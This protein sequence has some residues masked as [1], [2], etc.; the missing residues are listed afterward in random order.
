MGFANTLM[1]LAGLSAAIPVIIHLWNRRRF[2][3]VRW[4]AMEYLLAAMR[5]HSRR[6]RIE[7]LILLV[8]RV[9]ILITLAVA[10]ADPYVNAGFRF[11]STLS[12][13]HTHWVFVIDGS[14]SMACQEDES[15]RFEIAKQQVS[16]LL[17]RAS[18]GD[19][20]T[21]ILMGDPPRTIIRQPAFA[22]EDVEEELEPLALPHGGGDLVAT[23]AE[24]Q[25]VI[26]AARRNTPRLT[27]TNVCFLTDLGGTSWNAVEKP[28][29]R[30]RVTEIAKHASLAVL[31]EGSISGANLAVTALA[32]NET[33]VTTGREV[34]YSADVRNFSSQDRS[35]LRAE[36]F[37]DGRKVDE[38]QIDVPALGSTTATF[39]H[40]FSSPQDHVVEVRI[41]DDVLPIDNRRQLSVPVRSAIKVLCVEGQPG[42]A[43]HTV[44]ALEPSTSAY[45][46]IETTRV[47]ESALIDQTFESFDC[48]LFCNVRR[49]SSD[50]SR[51]LK[52][53][54][55]NGGGVVFLLGDQVDSESY[56]QELSDGDEGNG[57]L[58]AI[59]GQP[60]ALG[61]YQFDPLEYRHAIVEP[62]RSFEQAGLLS[63]PVW[64]YV[65][66]DTVDDPAVKTALA[67]DNGDPAIV[68]RMVGNG[69]VIVYAGAASSLSMDRTTAPPSP[70]TAIQ[71]WPSFPP[72]IQEMVAL[73]VSGQTERQNLLVGDSL[74]GVI[75]NVV[76]EMSLDV[77][78]PVGESQRLQVTVQGEDSSWSFGR[79]EQSGT[80]EAQFGPP[81]DKT[82]RF[83]VN[84]D[85]RESNLEQIDPELLPSQF[86]D[87]IRFDVGGTGAVAQA[88]QT[89]IFQFALA[90][91]LILLVAESFLAWQFGRARLKV[92]T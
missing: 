23:L 25:S 37:I 73:A 36:F 51:Q 7:Q 10:L 49:I 69:R 30:R 65:K 90:A 66:L 45:R 9:L 88:N 35:Q 59:V 52:S 85:T 39:L 54:T 44:I 72:L 4:A 78:T 33:L 89:K 32:Q 55:R 75:P 62:F 17:A 60:V 47:A 22:A 81:L 63:S 83:A 74:G 5:K 70:W 76:A 46:R 1:L 77:A 11:A 38:E 92:G 24:V 26:E 64:K 13:G 87:E 48:I 56:N 84:V 19:G 41:E 16:R 34:V 21:L 91:L 50:V 12:S 29:S 14:Y 43:R 57:F 67:F 68:E 28:E 3:E 15:S 80:Y 42:A 86:A 6:I 8:V 18:Q 20:F 58:P 79:T 40:R 31:N 27:A 53:F 2:R 61:Q 82:R 71:T